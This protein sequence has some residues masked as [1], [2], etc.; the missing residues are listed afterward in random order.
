KSQLD[1]RA[2]DY[3]KQ[4]QYHWWQIAQHDSS[5]AHTLE[6]H[7]LE[8]D[9]FAHAAYLPLFTFTQDKPQ[10]VVILP[11][12]MSR[13]ERLT[14]KTQPVIEELETIGGNT[15][16]DTHQVFLVNVRV[17]INK[18]AGNPPVLC[19]NKQALRIDVEPSGWSQATQ[20]RRIKRKRR[21]RGIM[22]G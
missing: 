8:P 9:H 5:H 3:K 22:Q 19:Q 1:P 21:A 20:V 4:G 13:L 12:D 6:T 10:L 18:L 16:F 11:L 7:H 14:V 2:K 15:A 17:L